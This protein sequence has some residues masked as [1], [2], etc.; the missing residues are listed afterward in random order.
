MD[1][2]TSSQ[3]NLENN[4]KSSIGEIP[5]DFML[6]KQNKISIDFTLTTHPTK[7]PMVNVEASYK[8]FVCMGLIWFEL[9]PIKV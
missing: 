1:H 4:V 5:M 8:K 2:P 6:K 9:S 7:K 3:K